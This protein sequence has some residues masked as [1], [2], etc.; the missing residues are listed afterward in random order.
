ME[1]DVYML[2]RRIRP[3]ISNTSHWNLGL[4]N[5]EVP[6]DVDCEKHAQDFKNMHFSTPAVSPMYGCHEATH[7]TDPTQLTTM[8]TL[9]LHCRVMY[10]EVVGPALFLQRG[11]T[12]T[13][14]ITLQQ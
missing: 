12:E 8:Y 5:M 1:L 4:L 11:T 13:P 6:S 9:E 7:H 2:P 10:R 14:T 3:E